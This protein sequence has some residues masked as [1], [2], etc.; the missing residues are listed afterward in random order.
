MVAARAAAASSPKGEGM[1]GFWVLFSVL[2]A[3]FVGMVIGS[4]TGW[5]MKY[6]RKEK[7]G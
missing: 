3:V 6:I 7:K 1:E 4:A 2:F 5:P